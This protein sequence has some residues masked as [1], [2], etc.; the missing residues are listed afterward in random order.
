MSRNTVVPIFI[1]IFLLA[2]VGVYGFLDVR[3]LFNILNQN[4]IKGI[5]AIGMTVNNAGAD[6]YQTAYYSRPLNPTP[7]SWASTCACSIRSVTSPSSRTRS[8]I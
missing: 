7:R 2:S 3:N 5:M 1:V 8:R 6:P 4:A